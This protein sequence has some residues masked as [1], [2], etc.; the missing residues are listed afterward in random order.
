MKCNDREKEIESFRKQNIFMHYLLP[1]MNIFIALD[2]M[3][4]QCV[5]YTKQ[6][7]LK[8][9]LRIEHSDLSLHPETYN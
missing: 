8:N 7:T 2:V 3:L 5:Q 9:V 1:K 4:A 6:K